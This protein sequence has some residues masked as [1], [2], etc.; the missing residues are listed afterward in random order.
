MC[1]FAGSP[2]A[3]VFFAFSANS[4]GEFR[5][6]LIIGALRDLLNSSMSIQFVTLKE[7]VIPLVAENDVVEDPD[8]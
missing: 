1:V 8:A 4:L 6:G 2:S 3:S 5:G 7:T